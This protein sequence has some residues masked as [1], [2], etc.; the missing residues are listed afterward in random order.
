MIHIDQKEEKRHRENSSQSRDSDGS[1]LNFFCSRMVSH[2][3]VIMALQAV[4]KL[5]VGG[6]LRMTDLLCARP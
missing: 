6:G 1:A 3:I 5:P 4:S 2:T